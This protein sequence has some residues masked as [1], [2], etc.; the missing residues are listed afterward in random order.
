M[1][2]TLLL[3]LLSLPLWA[4]LPAQE[5]S[6]LLARDGHARMIAAEFLLPFPDQDGD[7]V[8]EFLIGSPWQDD[9]GLV[10]LLSGASLEVIWSQRRPQGSGFG[11]R[12]V[13]IQDVDGDQVPE[14]G[15]SEPWLRQGNL[16]RGAVHLLSGATG[17]LRWS[18]SAH[19]FEL[20]GEA[21]TAIPDQN[22]D[23]IDELLA[24]APGSSL[25][26]SGK[27]AVVLISGAQGSFLRGLFGATAEERL[28]SAVGKVG[29]LDG[30]GYA[31]ALVSALRPAGASSGEVRILS[32]Q[33]GATLQ[34]LASGRTFDG[35]GETLAGLPD[36]DGDGLPDVVVGA[37]RSDAGGTNAGAVHLFSGATGAEI[38]HVDGTQSQGRFG[39]WVTGMDDLDGDQVSDLACGAQ[40][41]GDGLVHTLSA[42][43]GAVLGTFAPIH[44]QSLFGSWIGRAGDRDGDGID[45]LAIA[46]Q[47]HPELVVLSPVSGALLVHIAQADERDGLGLQLAP[48]GDLDGD[49]RPDLISASRSEKVLVLA[50]DDLHTL[51]E[52]PNPTTAWGFG[53]GLAGGADVDGDGLD[54]LAA[55]NPRGRNAT[56]QTVGLVHLHSGRDGSELL[57]MEGAGGR[58]GAALAFFPDADGDGR[59]DLLSGAPWAVN[60]LGAASGKLYLLSSAHGGLLLEAEGHLTQALFGIAFAPIHDL[61]SDGRRDLAVGA[62]ADRLLTGPLPHG[63]VRALSGRD[64]SV[65]IEIV[66]PEP[67]DRFGEA[68]VSLGDLDQDGVRDLVVGAPGHPV[69]GVWN[70]GAVHAYSG[71]TGRQLW[72]TL[73][74][75]T[76]AEFGR[77]VAALGDVDGDGLPDVLVQMP[78]F[79]G[80]WNGPLGK[81]VVL[82]GHDGRRLAEVAG[83]ARFASGFG[84]GLAGLPDLDGDGL[85]EFAF[86]DP[87]SDSAGAT[88]AGRIEVWGF[89]HSG[90]YLAPV[91]LLAG[92]PSELRVFGAQGQAVG[93]GLSLTGAGPTWIPRLGQALGLS[94]PI[95]ALGTS[96]P[97]ASGLA[98]LAG[99]VP[100]AWLGRGIWLQA[101]D[102]TP[103][104][105][106][107]SNPLFRFVR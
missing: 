76:S 45:D 99:A 47:S 91:E 50:G 92:Q 43:G 24:G 93:F 2:S 74:D 67:G 49:G 56:N 1:R 39:S 107:V 61:D 59:E 77:R 65:L 16:Y 4:P 9:G 34:T 40:R 58:F 48:T 87:L 11:F 27:G 72:T 79:F 57:R 81:V 22:G 60:S 54:D 42:A 30:D 78:R 85:A 83:P 18:L 98:V 36:V 13:L 51:F 44:G 5:A 32:M 28:G 6:L 69:G 101:V 37:P 100:A 102:W 63:V 52:V 25:G 68:L 94:R 17:E 53:E 55:G 64:F 80:G 96:V 105:P 86:G 46:A 23:G 95:H 62:P 71:A 29:D 103:G 20:L 33:T 89:D 88:D 14:I 90:P 97:N 31:E 12:L 73:S 7:A 84:D 106:A 3:G 104:S 8:E 35:F 75:Q 21:L 66:G 26:S 82:S 41:Q 15:V 70:S 19:P 38:L 10:H